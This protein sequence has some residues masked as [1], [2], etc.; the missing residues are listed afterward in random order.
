ML[1]LLI[2]NDENEIKKIQEYTAEFFPSADIMPFSDSARAMEFICSDRFSVD[3]CFTKI[4]M[5]NVS[6]FKIA[7]ELKS[8][9]PYAKVVFMEETPDYAGEAWKYGVS[10]YIITPITKEAVK[11]AKIACK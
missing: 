5:P 9:N 11:H 7:K 3:L 10:D 4:I 1:I 6:G 8:K 2:E